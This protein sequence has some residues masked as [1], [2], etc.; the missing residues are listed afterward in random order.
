MPASDGVKQI[1]RHTSTPILLPRGAASGRLWFHGVLLAL[2]A[3]S[4]LV[5]GA[6]LEGVDP[7][8]TRFLTVGDVL[9]PYPTGLRLS[10]LGV[11][12]PFAAGFLGILLTHEMGHYVAARRHG[13]RVSLPY[14][15][16]FP[17]YFSLVGTLGAFI[18]MRSVVRTRNALLDVGA[19]GPWAGFVVSIPVLWWGLA[20]STPVPGPAS[21]TTPFLIRFLGEPILLG[22]SPL[23]H[24]AGT[25]LFPQ[26]FGEAPIL[27]HPLALAGWLGLFVT[28]LNLLP[29]GQLDGG[30]VLFAL[31]GR[32]QRWPG[33][34]ALA[35][36]IPLGVVWW[37]WW[38]WAGVIWGVN[39]GRVRHPPTG[40]DAEPP[41]RLRTLVGVGALLLLPLVF[42]PVPLVM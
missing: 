9:L 14:F 33:R 12:A 27:L 19:S 4:T 26:A 32:H 24:L 8:R 31:V 6:F 7:L 11:G 15:I 16:P 38:L 2:T 30:H 28:A 23:L 29:V 5:A 36:L 10:A 21:A 37:G 34:L 25:A 17:P 39:R 42:V 35:V 3:V 20:A 40:A 22:S 13:I 18:R 41:G 1:D